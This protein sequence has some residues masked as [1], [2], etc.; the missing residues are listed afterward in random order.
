MKQKSEDGPKKN[1]SQLVEIV[2]GE[3]PV[4]VCFQAQ[5]LFGSVQTHK[6]TQSTLSVLHHAQLLLDVCKEQEV[7][8]DGAA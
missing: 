4:V 3:D 1:N 7:R 8:S 5:L 6:H 2:L